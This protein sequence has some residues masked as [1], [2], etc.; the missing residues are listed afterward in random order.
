MRTPSLRLRLYASVC[1]GV[2]ALSLARAVSL[3]VYWAHVR[4]G[5]AGGNGMALVIIVL[6]GAVVLGILLGTVIARRAI[7][8][9]ASF[10]AALGLA[11][12][13]VVALF[14]VLF[15]LEVWRTRE[16]RQAQDEAARRPREHRATAA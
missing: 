6:P 12:L 5:T 14:V 8:R 11:F 1:A 10:R 16:G 3:A 2:L 7:R 4:L 13:S 9:G 15:M